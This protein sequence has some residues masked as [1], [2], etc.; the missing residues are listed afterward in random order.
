[1]TVT[2]WVRCVQPRRRGR[3]AVRR[4]RLHADGSGHRPTGLSDRRRQGSAAGPP[5]PT[6]APAGSAPAREGPPFPGRRQNVTVTK[7]RNAWLSRPVVDEVEKLR[8]LNESDAD[9]N[10]QPTV[11]HGSIFLFH[12]S[13]RTRKRWRCS[14][15]CRG[16]C[17]CLSLGFRCCR[18]P[19][20]NYPTGR[21]AHTPFWF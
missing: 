1:M 10:G 19:A 11:V 20:T 13:L 5:M 21:C 7:R 14:R 18:A 16:Q 12:R 17:G 8:R 4:K 2:R 9:I 3:V 15:T 6:R